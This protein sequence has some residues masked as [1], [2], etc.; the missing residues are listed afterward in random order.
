MDFLKCI[1]VKELLEITGQ[2]SY[3]AQ[4]DIVPQFKPFQSFREKNSEEV[5]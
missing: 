5:L 1:G 3:R 4:E 2:L